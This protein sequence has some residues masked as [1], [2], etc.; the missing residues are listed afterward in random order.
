MDGGQYFFATNFYLVLTV[1]F[2]D[3]GQTRIRAFSN[4]CMQRFDAFKEFRW[5]VLSIML[6]RRVL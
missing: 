1:F 5:L 6:Q 2:P 4:K 3:C